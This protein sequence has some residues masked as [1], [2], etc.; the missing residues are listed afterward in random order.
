M[1][2]RVR[3]VVSCADRKR[4]PPPVDLQLRNY[5]EQFADRVEQWTSRLE[6]LGSSRLPANR[7]Y[8][9]EHWS[10]VLQLLDDAHGAGVDAELWIASAGYGLIQMRDEIESYAATFSPNS[11]DSVARSRAESEFNAA[12][13]RHVSTWRERT[14]H[15]VSS[16]ATLVD[17]DPRAT[18]LVALSA[19]YTRAL[20]EDLLAAARS[21]V[22]PDHLLLISA[23]DATKELEHIRIPA[24]ARLQADLGGTLLSLNARIARLLVTE[25]D[26]HHWNADRVRRRLTERLDRLPPLA[27]FGRSPMTDEQ[28]RDFVRQALLASPSSRSTLLRKLRD[29]GRACE[30]KRFSRL[31][32]EALEA[33]S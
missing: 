24:D 19:S 4:L 11:P 3:I 21:L 28:V 18:V 29:A 7:M 31:Y 10:V 12:W 1:A 8:K 2:R 16:I 26:E 20:Q 22:R 9:G 13:W 27:P 30:Q 25:A 15:N 6:S 17:D 14:G 33:M 23:G 5:P 32:Q